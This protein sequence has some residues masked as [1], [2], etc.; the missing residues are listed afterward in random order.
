M[1]VLCA[2]ATT[3]N[4]AETITV[5]IRH[6]DIRGFELTLQQQESNAPTGETETISYI[7]WEPSLGKIGTTAYE[8]NKTPQNITH[9][10]HL[11]Y[12][13]T[14]F[15]SSPSMISALQTCNGR[16]TASL[17]WQDKTAYFVY[18]QI[19]EEQSQDPEI[20][21]VDESVGYMLFEIDG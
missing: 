6:I 11:L 10:K 2:T 12:F 17:R 16:D 5:R 1:P 4:G 21:H 15:S 19:T 7:A 9:E 18:L 8:V 14:R 20:V 3:F 13:Q